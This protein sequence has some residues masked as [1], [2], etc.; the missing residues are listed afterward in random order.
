M[1]EIMKIRFNGYR[2]YKNI[3]EELGIREIYF[4]PTIVYYYDEVYMPSENPHNVYIA[5]LFWKLDIYW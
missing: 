4:L 5:W 1:G 2:S 3:K